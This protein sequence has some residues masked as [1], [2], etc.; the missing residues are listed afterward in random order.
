MTKGRF[1]GHLGATF[2]F[3]WG[4]LGLPLGPF[5]LPTFPPVEPYRNRKLVF[6]NSSR[7]ATKSSLREHDTG[8]TGET[9]ETGGDGSGV[10]NG[11]SDPTFH[12]C[13]GPG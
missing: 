8:E 7:L 1:G 9:G 4:T 5:A 3:L 10:K 13:R 12:A 11:G 6:S 2:G